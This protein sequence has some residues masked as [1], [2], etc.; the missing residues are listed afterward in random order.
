MRDGRSTRDARARAGAVARLRRDLG[1]AL[2]SGAGRV[3]VAVDGSSAPGSPVLDLERLRRDHPRAT[4]EVLDVRSGGGLCGEGYAA[5]VDATRRPDLRGALF[6]STF[7]RLRPGGTFVVLDHRPPGS[8]AGGPVT[9]EVLWPRL[10]STAPLQP[11]VGRIVLDEQHLCVERSQGT[12]PDSR[13]R[14]A[15]LPVVVRGLVPVEHPTI[16]VAGRRSAARGAARLR[17]ELPGAQVVHVR[18]GMPLPRRHARLATYGPFD[19]MV[20]ATYDAGAS[21][22]LLRSGFLHVR[23]GG[24]LL[25]LGGSPLGGR[26]GATAAFWETLTDVLS[27]RGDEPFFEGSLELEWSRLAV[28]IGRV[29][30]RPRHVVLTNRVSAMALLRDRQL[31]QVAEGRNDPAIQVHERQPPRRFTSR[32]RLGASTERDRKRMPETYEVP[33]LQVHEYLDVTCL[34]KQVVTKGNLVLPDTFRHPGYSWL[35]NRRLEPMGRRFVR[36]VRRP[37]SRLEGP[38]FHLDGELRHHFGHVTTEHLSRLWAWPAAKAANP[39]LR[40]LVSIGPHRDRLPEWQSALYEAAGVPR[41]DIVTFRKGVVVDRLIGATPM[42]SMPTYVHPD[43]A[44][45]WDRIGATLE[46]RATLDTPPERIFI[47]RAPGSTRWCHETPELE[48]IVE[49]LGY[50][51]IRPELLPLPDQVRL[52]RRARSLAGFAGSGMFNLMF[53]PDPKPV[54]LIRSTGYTASNE[55][56]IAAVRGHHIETI[57]CCP[58]LDSQGRR[59]LASP[60]DRV[61]QSPAIRSAFH[62]DL[63]ADKERLEQILGGFR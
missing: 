23:R 61:N 56:M 44:E 33:A 52:F 60:A 39:D 27:R 11:P 55:Y 40:A 43:I 57:A 50:A 10:V 51:V 62:F 28:A 24:C 7:P 16:A 1:T 59:R 20:D 49:Q 26:Q 32:A 38:Y 25:V 46:S 63:G 45:V 58:D 48:R 22:D 19:L 53:A 5:V 6:D 8:D 37:T 12:H 18:T 2:G 15:E 54:L 9:E 30:V 42:F 47:T 41:D 4:L 29:D 14:G 13:R 3:L 34:P 36:G 35:T 17:R 21:A 31:L